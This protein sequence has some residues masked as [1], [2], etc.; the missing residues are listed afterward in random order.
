[1]SNNRN[2]IAAIG[3]ITWVGFLIAY[4]MGDRA[5][6]FVMHHLNQALVINLIGL[7]G[8]V[9]AVI[10]I[11]GTIASGVISLAMIVFDILGALT[12]YRSSMVPLPYIGNIHI[13]G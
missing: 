12:A 7:V 5:D 8:G 9:L 2:L 13:I 4:L 6:R 10:P 1:M 11:L 3:Y